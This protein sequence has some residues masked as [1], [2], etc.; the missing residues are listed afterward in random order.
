MDLVSKPN[1]AAFVW[2]H[3]SNRMTVV[4]HLTCVSRPVCHI[5]RKTVASK[6]A[7]TTNMHLHPKHNHHR[8]PDISQSLG[9]L[10][11]ANG[12]HSDSVVC[13]MLFLFQFY[14]LFLVFIQVHFF[15]Q[16]SLFLVF[17]SFIFIVNI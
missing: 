12:A 5:Y 1:A 3:T 4:N 13:L 14:L 9:S 16:D 6:R 11:G 17:G 8:L 2:E 15:V 10:V 7:N